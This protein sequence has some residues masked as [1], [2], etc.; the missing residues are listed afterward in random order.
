MNPMTSLQGL[1]PPPNLALEN[2]ERLTNFERE[3]LE[4]RLTE[5]RLH[6]ALGREEILLRQ[7][8]ELATHQELL[9]RESDHRLLNDLQLV[10]SLLS[11]Q[12]RKSKNAEVTSQLGIAANRVATIERIHRRLHC[13]DGTQAVGFREYLKDFCRDISAMLF[14][15]G[16]RG[17]DVESTDVELP[18][19]VAIPLGFIVNELITNAAKYGEGRIVVCLKDC[20]EGGYALSVSN[21]GPPLPNGFDP[22]ASKGLGMRIIR[23]FIDKMA[24]TLHVDC[25]DGDRGPAFEIRFT[26][27][28]A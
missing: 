1:T 21:D 17:V 20:P 25:G 16:D 10:V 13:L 22:A 26:V 5:A 15:D 6:A 11:L 9:R 4:H 18:T 28:H 23:S 3:R 24:G 8:S 2:Y 7:R 12:G 14:L 27:Q 19:T